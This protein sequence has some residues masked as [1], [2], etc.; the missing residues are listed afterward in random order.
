MKRLALYFI[1]LLTTLFTACVT[2][3]PVPKD[4][5]S[6]LSGISNNTLLFDGQQGSQATFSISSKL[7]WE[8]LDTPGVTYSPSS[9]EATPEG[10][11]TVIT[12]TINQPNNTLQVAEV[13]DVIFRLSRTRF[14]GIVARQNPQIIIAQS[15]Q[16]EIDPEQNEYSTVEFECKSSELSVSGEGFVTCSVVAGSKPNKYTLSVASTKDNLT[17]ENATAGYVS[18]SIN[19][20][21]QEG[22]IAINQ[23]PAIVA[24]RSR[25]TINGRRGSTTPFTIETPFDFTVTSS[26]PSFTATKGA[27]NEVIL[28]ATESN[29]GAEERKLGVLTLTLTANPKCSVDIEVWQRTN[30]A[31]QAMLYYFLGTSL[32]SYYESN[33]RM[34]E[35]VAAKGTLDDCRL[36]AFLQSSR[37]AGEMF[38]I[39]YD[40]GLDRVLREHIGDYTLPA[41]YN[42][43]MVHQILADMIANAPATEYGLFIGSHGKGWLPKASSRGATT[44]STFAV[45]K[46]IWTPAPGAAM[47]RHI[48]DSDNTQLNITELAQAIVRT[49][50]KLNYMIFDVCYMANVESAYDLREC[51]DY[52]LASPCEVMASGMPYNEIVPIMAGE[53]AVKTRLESAAKAFVDSYSKEDSIYSSA[54]SAVINCNEL[55]AL[56]AA[57]KRVNGSLQAID[58]KTL[59]AF[60]GISPSSNPT[61]IFFDI[62]DYVTKSCT[63]AAAVSAFKAQLAATVTGQYHTKTFY[64]AYN[65]KANPINTYSGLTTSAPIT[66]DSKSAY[67][68]EWKNT[69]WAQITG[70]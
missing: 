5:L 63:D 2:L 48:G 42:E 45:D 36:I 30:T 33:L 53:G 68:E 21:R 9:G 49:G 17:A 55:D 40:K 54:C 51:A 43:D 22:K 20:T 8:I 57:M 35:Q 13:G 16:I 67:I 34:V 18:F 27:D 15:E 3:E 60:D 59:Q 7:P 25:M 19:G 61:H 24:N 41:V 29:N 6:V 32:S 46:S 4:S 58:H 28:T 37:N 14:T 1:L 52:I 23:R 65:N 47:V 38:E 66:L 50:H 70:N 31:K 56:A 39:V 11:R 44:Y 26:S 12:A 62:E 64:S 10:E 69:A